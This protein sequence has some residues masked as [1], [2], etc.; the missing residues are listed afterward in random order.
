MAHNSSP[1]TFSLQST[2]LSNYSTD[3][4]VTVNNIEV[5]V[6][7]CTCTDVFTTNQVG[8][9]TKATPIIPGTC[10]INITSKSSWDKM[11]YAWGFE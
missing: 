1:Y 4:T 10:A 9:T 5:T 2:T 8:Y 11:L 6:N 7:T 3:F